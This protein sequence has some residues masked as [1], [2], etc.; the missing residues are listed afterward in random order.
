MDSDFIKG[1]K[2]EWTDEHSN[3]EYH[4]KNDHCSASTLKSIKKSP[5]HWKFTPRKQT[6]AFTFGSAY[7]AYILEPDVFEE[8]FFVFDETQILYD[9]KNGVYMDDKGKPIVSSKP[10]ATKPYKEWKQQQEVLA[11]GK[12]IISK[13]MMEEIEKMKRVLLKN[14]YVRNLL[15]RGVAERSHYVEIETNTDQKIKTRIRPDYMKEKRRVVIDLKTCMDASAD[16]F[17][18]DAAKLHY[19]IQGAFY[20]DLL[21]KIYS[22]G[23]PW[24]F[25]FIAQEKKAPYAYNI[26]ECSHR[27]ISQGRYEYE[28]LLLLWQWCIENDKFPGY[29]VWCDN[30]YGIQTLDLPPY[31]MKE[32]N[33]YNH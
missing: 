16:M 18:K 14:H 6:D 7:H 20:A 9:L 28:M 13:E 24:T 32:V 12:T 15:R 33:W 21:E 26:F 25:I 23:E 8:E 1:I 5:A 2:F 11:A 30:K 4:G 3:E 10:R 19:H 22:P 17:A 31:A 29:G 27:M